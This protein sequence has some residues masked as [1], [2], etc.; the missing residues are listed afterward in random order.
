[1][2]TRV[3]LLG[4]GI[5][6]AGMARSMLRAGLDVAV[7]NRSAAKAAPLAADGASV[8][9]S[10]SAA[11]RDAEVLVTMLFDTESVAS[12]A[13]QALP[14]LADGAVWAQTSTVGLDGAAQ[15]GEV[16]A[17]HGVAYVDAPVMGTRQPAENGALTVLAAGPDPTRDVVAPVFDAIGAHTSWVSERPGDAQRLKLVMNA[18]V[19][20]LVAATG[21]S[22]ALARGLGVDPQTFLDTIAGGPLDSAYAQV[23]AGAMLADEFPP[24][25][26]LDGAVKDTDL[27][28][29]AL[30]DAGLSDAV[31]AAVNGRFRAAADT[32][33]AHEDMA[34]VVHG[35]GA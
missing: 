16:A 18:W 22:V 8:H 11:A 26:A 14:V 31:M 9:D 28:A 15:L 34:A 12:G 23:K 1:M 17:R 13:A 3:A 32:G 25:F 4:T 10:P 19:L 20:S 27:I 2:S 24:A 7:W 21:Q 30:R 5:M 33:R 6:G 35:Y 29:A